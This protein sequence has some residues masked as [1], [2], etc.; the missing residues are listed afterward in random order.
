MEQHQSIP[1]LLFTIQNIILK[2]RSL[3]ILGCPSDSHIHPYNSVASFVVQ[4]GRQVYSR[5]KVV[6]LGF[7]S[8]KCLF[9]EN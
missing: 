5:Y 6:S 1:T 2:I 8:E 3:Y 7:E 9:S 4:K